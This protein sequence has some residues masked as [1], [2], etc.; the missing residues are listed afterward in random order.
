MWSADVSSASPKFNDPIV[1]KPRDARRLVIG[2]VRANIE[3]LVDI[4]S[5]ESGRSDKLRRNGGQAHSGMTAAQKRQ[6]AL[7]QLAQA[8]DPPGELRDEGPRHDND[9]E[10]ISRI[11]VAPT[12][13]ELLCESTYLPVFSPHAPHHLRESSMERHLDIQFRLLR[14]ELMYVYLAFIDSFAN[15]S[16]SSSPIR[17]SVLAIYNDIFTISRNNIR[18]C[19]DRSKTILEDLIQKRGGAYKTSGF[20]S[21]FFHVYTNVQFCPMRAQ[22]RD[23]TVGLSLDAPKAARNEDHKKRYAY[24][25]YSKRLQ[26]GGLIVLVMVTGNAARIYLGVVQSSS[27]DIAESS[28]AS[29]DSIQIQVSFFD[30]EVEWMALRNESM[31]PSASSYALLLDNSVMYEASRPFLERLQS[32]EPTEIPFSRYI[33]RHDS[34]TDVQ[35]LPPKYATAPGFTFNLQCLALKGYAINALDIS[36]PM[37]VENAHRQLQHGSTLDPSQLDAVLNSLTRE[38]SLVQGYV[39]TNC[40]ILP[41]SSLMPSNLQTTRDGQGK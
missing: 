21:V 12:H 29:E 4:V 3:R 11:R 28:K 22:R 38:V 27:K 10:D 20:D 1:D 23:L 19:K 31:S 36:Q 13:E 9:F 34:I 6:A 26:S 33:A 5:R 14:E 40:S 7:V 30:S 17:S 2:H 16:S 15:H 32:I 18:K 41:F 39:S 35:I 24:W 8:Y 25:E 37:A